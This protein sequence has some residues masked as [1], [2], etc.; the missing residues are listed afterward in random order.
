MRMSR[1]P[2]GRIRIKF[3]RTTAQ[4]LHSVVLEAFVGPRPEGLVGRHLDGDPSNN[5][6]SNLRWGTAEENYDDRRSH[7]T[8]ND[9]MRNGRAK[10]TDDQVRAIRSSNERYAD[11][12]TQHGVAVITISRVRRRVNWRHL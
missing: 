3:G 2:S 11:L 9:G 10:L 7:G 4:F 8:E 5:K 12:A 1:H 6:L